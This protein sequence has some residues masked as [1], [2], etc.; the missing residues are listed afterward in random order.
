MQTAKEKRALTVFK[1]T[2]IKTFK[3]EIRLLTKTTK[4]LND[5]L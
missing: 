2:W 5:W 4:V 1:R 3:K